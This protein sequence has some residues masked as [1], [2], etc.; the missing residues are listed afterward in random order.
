MTMVVQ[1]MKE[2][3]ENAAELLLKRIGQKEPEMPAEIVL[4]TRIH[5][6]ESVRKLER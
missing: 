5:Q 6:G 3:G 1:P 4:G 2:M